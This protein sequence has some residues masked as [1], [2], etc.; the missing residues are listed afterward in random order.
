MTPT[1]GRV[2]AVLALAF[3]WSCGSGGSTPEP[4]PRVAAPTV[5]PAGPLNFGA[6]FTVTLT[7]A[8]AGAVVHCTV[9]GTEPTTTSP[10]CDAPFTVTGTTTVKAFAT[11]AGMEASEP[12]SSTFTHRPITLAADAGTWGPYS[13]TTVA[14]QYLVANRLTPAPGDYPFLL[15]TVQIAFFPKHAGT[16]IRLAVYA[17]A[18]GDWANGANLLATLDT[19][20]LNNGAALGGATWSVYQLPAPILVTGPGDLL[21]GFVVLPPVTT[22]DWPLDPADSGRTM[23]AYWATTVPNPPALPSYDFFGQHTTALIRASD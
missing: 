11:H 12:V 15:R 14:D 10:A 6:P 2:L 23:M 9:D 19:T 5:S 22:F 21:V 3:T 17:D 7:T 8:T 16:A 18:D 1:F 4:L 13:I 20:V